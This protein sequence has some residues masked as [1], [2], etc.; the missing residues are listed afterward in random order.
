MPQYEMYLRNGQ[1]VRFEADAIKKS[2]DGAIKS[3]THGDSKRRLVY[4]EH[5]EPVAIVEIV[6]DQEPGEET[7]AD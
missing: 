1:V 7:N 2:A 6:D 5:D 4:L 3:W